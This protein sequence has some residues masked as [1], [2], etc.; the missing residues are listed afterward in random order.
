MPPT[1]TADAITTEPAQT[2]SRDRSVDENQASMAEPSPKNREIRAG[3]LRW[4]LSRLASMQPAEIAWRARSAA[5]LPLDWANWKRKASAPAP[6]WTPIN[7]ETYPVSPHN[8]GVAMEKIHI[9]DLEFPL[10]FEFDWHHDYRNSKQVERSFA[11]TLNIRDTAIVSDIKYVWEPSRFQHLSALAYADNAEQHTDYIVRSLDSWTQANPYLYGVHWTSSLELAERVI[12]WALI[13]PRIADRVAS[14]ENFRRRWLESIY[15]HLER[16]SRKLSFYSSANNHLIGELVGLYVGATCFD[17]WP[18]CAGW[19]DRARRL[20]ERE[21]RRQVGDDGVDREQAMSY[22]LFVME[23]FLLAFAIGRNTG[24]PFSEGYAERLRAMAGFLESVATPSGDLPWY[25]D[26]DDARGFVLSEDESGLDV[27]MQLAALLFAKPEWL[28]FSRKASVA[29]LALVPDLIPDM[30]HHLTQ[31]PTVPSWATVPPRELFSDA[32]LASVRTRDGS[33]GLVMDFGPLGFPSP[34]GHGHADALSIWLAIGEEYFL[35]DAGTYAYH[36]HQDWRTYFRGTAAHNTARVDGQNQ[37]QIAGRFLWS[38]KANARLLHFENNA[39]EVVIDAE[40]DGYL[41][42]P[43]PVT[44]RRTV[45][46]DRKTGNTSIEDN[47]RGSGRHQIELFFHMHEDAEVLSLSDG[48][49]VVAWR[50]RH[51]TFSSPDS[52]IWQV[53]RGSEDPKLGWRSHRFNQKQLIATLRV[54]AE[55]DGTSTIRTLIQVNS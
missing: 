44:H 39:D 17:F 31:Q 47:F 7:P 20:L 1:D 36:S 35:V 27:T 49:A 45:A 55:I 19:R 30:V 5:T 9:F 15:R 43:E 26:S 46:L 14:E 22:H 37:S 51:I 38:A 24:R 21:I 4:Y 33:V 50:G 12:S 54:L 34:A 13:Y 2:L 53:V 18:E 40:H 16:I 10:G 25:G 42:L 23:L 32:G 8:T 28:T 11:G 52:A 41:R 29:S 6:Q 48:Q 3:K